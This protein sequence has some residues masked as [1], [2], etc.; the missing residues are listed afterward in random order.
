MGSLAAVS[1]INPRRSRGFQLTRRDGD[2]AFRAAVR[3]SRHIRFLRVAIPAGIALGLIGTFAVSML[4]RGPLGLLAKLPVDIGSLV[5]SGTKIMMQ[6][7]KVAGF[8]RDNRRYNLT[9]NAAGQ[10]LTKPDL[11]ELHGIHA[12]MDMK[13]NAVFDITAKDGIYNSK[14]DLLTL[15]DDIVVTSSS[16]YRVLMSEAV[17]E[18][19]IGKVVSDKP[20]EVSTSTW[21]INA[22]RME[23]LDSGDVMRFERGVDVLMLPE[24]TASTRASADAREVRK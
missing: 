14:T 24:T 17:I 22:N 19:K 2:R 1:D 12:T 10:D 9:A 23:V 13:D 8:T 15:T 5:V 18:I 16:G 7:P 20:V 6:A 21:T 3:H 11:V 4:L